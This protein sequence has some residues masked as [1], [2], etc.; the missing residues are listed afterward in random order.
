MPKLLI[1]SDLHLSVSEREYSFNV[2]REIIEISKDYDALFLLGD[3]FDT[4]EDL[5]ELKE[6][7]I[8]IIE[9]NKIYLL[10]GNHEN[11]KSKGIT[12]SQLNFPSN[13]TV[14]EEISAFSIDDLDI[15]ALPYNDKY[16]VNNEFLKLVDSLKNEKRILLAHGIVEGTLWAIE[17]NEA[18]ASIP[19]D[20][21]K[22]SNVDLAIVGH[23]H[24]QMDT[25][26]ENI[27][28]VY[29][30]SSRVWR[31]S[32]AEIGIRRCLALEIK[33]NKI[34]KEYINI[35][36]AGEYRVYECNSYDIET[37]IESLSVNWKKN[38]IIS[39]NIY[40]IIEDENELEKTKKSIINKYSKNVRD[41]NLKN[42]QLYFLENAYN[43]R[44]IK[45]FL[46]VVNSYEFDINNKDN[47]EI[48]ELAKR[49]GI[50]KIYNAL[51]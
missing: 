16:S 29:P 32:K 6:E 11:L 49:L 26:I 12:L 18:S 21:I 5:K 14:L 3:T 41:I 13:I 34:K 48:L 25:R 45:E 46:D 23:I 27:E 51:Q 1:A 9:E 4:F 22:K 37:K 40:G 39:I 50:E 33:N 35:E 24:K 44:I 2:L 42:S 30:G 31:R 8:S 20:I 47:L 7:F 43:E 19:I 17:E 36:S 10:K 38:D 28:I 15:V